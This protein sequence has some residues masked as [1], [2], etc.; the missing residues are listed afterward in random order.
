VE[1]LRGSAVQRSVGGSGEELPG[2]WL[3]AMTEPDAAHPMQAGGLAGAPDILQVSRVASG[4]QCLA[5]EKPCACSAGPSAVLLFASQSSRD[6]PS[7]LEAVAARPAQLP[8]LL[9]LLSTYTRVHNACMRFAAESRWVLVFMAAR[10]LYVM[11]LSDIHD[12]ARHGRGRRAVPVPSTAVL[13]KQWRR[14]ARTMQ[15]Q[16]AHPTRQRCGCEA[17]TCSK[18]DIGSVYFT[19]ARRFPDIA[20][21][22]RLQLRLCLRTADT[23]RHHGPHQ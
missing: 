11:A 19:A 14:G 3:P 21:K 7:A 1:I 4:Q 5:G 18:L 12:H 10:P 20:N 17:R 6:T 23:S 22:R 15:M 9:R 2:G 16:C 13:S 8:V